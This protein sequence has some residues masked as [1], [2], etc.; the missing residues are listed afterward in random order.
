MSYCKEDDG[1]LLRRK[2]PVLAEVLLAPKFTGPRAPGL[3]DL[4]SCGPK[5]LSDP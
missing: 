3:R 1:F 4:A 5:G 2:Y